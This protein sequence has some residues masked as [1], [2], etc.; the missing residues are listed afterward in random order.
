MP[1]Q[2]LFSLALSIHGSSLIDRVAKSPRRSIYHEG[3][4]YEE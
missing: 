1:L 4:T 3:A 2:E